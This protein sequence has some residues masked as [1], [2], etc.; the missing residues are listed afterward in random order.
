MILYAGVEAPGHLAEAR[1]EWPERPPL[2]SPNP[3]APEPTGTVELVRSIA[4]GV[5]RTCRPVQAPQGRAF[6]SPIPIFRSQHSRTACLHEY[7]HQET[8]FDAGSRRRQGAP[9]GHTVAPHD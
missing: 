2:L 4:S 3:S 9:L 1:A 6:N 5:V 8:K 7:G